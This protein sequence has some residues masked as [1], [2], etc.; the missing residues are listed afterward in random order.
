MK[1]SP[2]AVCS[3]TPEYAAGPFWTG[4]RWEAFLPSPYPVFLLRTSTQSYKGL[5]VLMKRLHVPYMVQAGARLSGRPQ[6]HTRGTVL[7]EI[8]TA[9]MFGPMLVSHQNFRTTA[10]AAML[11]P[12]MPDERR[13]T[14]AT[15]TGYITD[16]AHEHLL[17]SDWCSSSRTTSHPCWKTKV[18][19]SV[20]TAIAGPAAPAN[21]DCAIACPSL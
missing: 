7:K 10:W 1:V 3:L 12:F 18:P 14:I 9:E 5:S 20:K 6:R 11:P 4:L 19:L 16:D 13:I 21:P 17:G 8:S 2:P 15:D